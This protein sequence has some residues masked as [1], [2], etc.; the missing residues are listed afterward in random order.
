MGN[1]LLKRHNRTGASTDRFPPGSCYKEEPP[2]LKV[3][4]LH[5][6]LGSGFRA[7][8]PPAS[9]QRKQERR[10][11]HDGSVFRNIQMQ[12]SDSRFYPVKP[13]WPSAST[14]TTQEMTCRR[15]FFYVAALGRLAGP[16]IKLN[17]GPRSQQ[18]LSHQLFSDLAQFS[19][20]FPRVRFKACPFYAKDSRQL[21]TMP[22]PAS[23]AS[24]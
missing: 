19:A 9:C 21:F 18:P 10:S 12:E 2:V 17:R 11:G 13:R 16:F 8:C 7:R 1:C 6:S 24:S 3:W 22:L 20:V 23:R 15:R 14:S 4:L 5:N